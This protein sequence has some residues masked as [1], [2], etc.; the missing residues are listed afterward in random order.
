MK[1]LFMAALAAGTIALPGVAQAQV[2]GIATA[3][4]IIAIAG[5]KALQGASQQ[6]KTTY[7]SYFD[8]IQ[9]KL[10]QRQTVLL[11]LDKNKDKQVDDAELK[12]A[13]TA[14]S[15]A[16]KQLDAIEAEVQRLNIPR[17][18]AMVF[19]IESVLKQYEAAQTK[20]ITDRHI[21]VILKPD[22]F[23]YAPPSVDVTSAIT[24]ALDQ[25]VPTASVTPPANWQPSQTAVSVYEQIMQLQQQL[26]AQQPRGAAQPPAQPAQPQ[27]QPQGR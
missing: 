10:D 16:L 8:Q 26:A 12:A 17:E 6:I 27:A 23:I 22:S 15:P 9:T 7:K 25:L 20:V 18:K 2:S 5:S 14:K 4:P 13:K 21:A 1:P 19:A 3:N 24:T 11:Q